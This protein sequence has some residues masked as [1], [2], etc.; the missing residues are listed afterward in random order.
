MLNVIKVDYIDLV[1]LDLSKFENPETRKEL[2]REFF[3]AF[4][5]DGFAT[6]TGHGISKEVWDTQMDLANA[7]M[8]MDPAAKVPYE[9]KQTHRIQRS[10][11]NTAN[12]SHAVTP[13]EDKQGIYVGFKTAGGL[14]FHKE[15]NLTH[16]IWCRRTGDAQHIGYVLIK[17]LLTQIDFYNM[18]LSDPKVDRKHP[19][20]LVPHYA[21]TQKVMLYIR[22]VIQRKFLILLAMALEI[23]EEALLRTHEPGQSSSEYYRYVCFRFFILPSKDYL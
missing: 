18:L 22:D 1:N 3:T 14:G 10:A 2:A 8:T 16:H 6:V 12:M 11:V 15:V 20:H 9:G 17:I 19:P 13:E 5:Q 21:E 4:T 23:P 7:T